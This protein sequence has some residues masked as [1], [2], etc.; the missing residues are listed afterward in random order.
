MVLMLK[1]VRYLLWSCLT[2]VVQLFYSEFNF[3]A[4]L[5]LAQPSPWYGMFDLGLSDLT[6][7]LLIS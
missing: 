7:S 4:S 5:S 1:V 6:S 2:Q 3:L